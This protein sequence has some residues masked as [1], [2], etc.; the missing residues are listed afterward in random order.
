MIIST[1]MR[2]DIPAFY[3]NWFIRRIRE[4]YVMVRNPYYP[5]QITKYR[6]DPSCVDCID[7]C[8][9]NPEPMLKYLEELKKYNMLWYVT[10]T[11][12]GRDIEQNVPPKENVINSFKK[13]AQMLPNS[14][15]GWRYD[16]IFLNQEYT[17]ERHILEFEKI[18]KQLKGYTNTCVISFLDHYEKVKKNAPDLVCPTKEEQIEI[19][20]AFFKVGKYHG[21]RIYACC[22][23]EFLEKYGLNC[24]GCKSEKIISS[25]IPYKIK[26]PHTKH[27]RAGCKCF[28]G[29]DIGAYDSCGHLCRYCYANTNKR[30][31]FQNMKNHFDD[32]PLLI[33]KVEEGDIIYEKDCKSYQIKT[34]QLQLF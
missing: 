3:A 9:K 26:L 8:T 23:G 32:S 22:E 21:I 12:Y 31:V 6:L 14:F 1:G 4:G 11:P 10:I 28:M 33:G 13:L 24:N 5:K 15:V 17:I 2:T 18:A 30:I 25:T 7:F 29:N 27:I 16:P 34:E 19:A 20:T